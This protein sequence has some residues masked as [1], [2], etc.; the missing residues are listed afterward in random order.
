ANKKL[1]DVP[2]LMRV[3]SVQPAAARTAEPR[4]AAPRVSADVRERTP[5][6]WL[7]SIEAL[8]RAG[9]SDEADAEMRLF[10]RIYPDYATTTKK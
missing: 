8:R 5:A 7:N 4:T 10:R 6:A 2:H 3:R 9:R 1:D